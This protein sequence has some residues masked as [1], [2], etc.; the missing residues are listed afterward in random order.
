MATVAEVI[1]EGLRRAGVARLFGV[2]GGGSNLDVLEASRLQ[3]LPFV[4]CHQEWA[5]CI[6][7]AVTGDLTGRPGAALSTLGPGVTA[8]ASGLAH[9]FLDR[10]P[11]IHLTDRH[12]DSALEF[13]THQRLDHGALLAP[14]VKGS[15]TITADSVSHLVARA[16]DLALEEP[17]GPVHLDLPADVAR[18]PATAGAVEVG[19]RSCLAPTTAALDLAAQMILGA[20]RPLVVAGLGC[21][22]SDAKWLRAFCEALPSPCL[23]TYKAKGAVPD[24]HPLALGVFTGGVLEEAVVRRADLIIAFG[25]DP[26]ELIPRRWSS[27]AP[28]LSVTRCQSSEAGFCPPGGG[29]YFVPALEVVGDP[30]SILE[31]LAPRLVGRS[32]ADWD[33]VEVDRLKRERWAALEVT[34]PGLAPHRVVQIAREL[35][36]AGTIATVD[37]GAHMFPAT[38]YWDAVEPGELLI[39]NGL[40]TMG[41]ALPAAI[42][43]QLVHPDRHVI[44]FTGDGGLMMV[45][46]EL[47]TAARLRLPILVIVFDDGALSLI[48]IK[49][50]Q[51]GYEGASMR[52]QGPDLAALARSFGLEAFVAA[53]EGAF[54]SALGSAL[55]ASGPTL[56]DA[57]I[58]ASGYRR[59]LEIVR[60]APPR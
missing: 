59:T 26:V 53:D 39:S 7:A 47:E 40:A 22:G 6:M 57:R 18:E 31:E 15:V 51:K 1:V 34:V 43:A 17:R 38:A 58:D 46:A 29:G 20:R 9:A 11:M 35:T 25:V 14:I 45:A 23:T 60:G 56:I 55:A 28:V 36:P 4:L 42:A 10:S 24:P 5:G 3:D 49:Q 8:S 16:V 30:G 27:A 54:R 32:K 12:P 13:V 41:F 37:A 21:R 19:S 44:C 48:Q 52:Y 50:E 33:V 2:P